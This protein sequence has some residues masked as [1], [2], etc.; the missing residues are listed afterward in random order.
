[1][2]VRRNVV[3]ATNGGPSP[4]LVTKPVAT[5]VRTELAARSAS[6]SEG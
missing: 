1:V 5:A 2:V 4:G 3:A 6:S